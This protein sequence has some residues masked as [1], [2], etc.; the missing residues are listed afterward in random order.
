VEEIR[1]ELCGSDDFS[2]NSL[3][4]NIDMDLKDFISLNDFRTLLK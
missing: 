1:K 3:Y 2:L 4:E